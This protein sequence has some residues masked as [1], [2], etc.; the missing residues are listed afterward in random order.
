M[1]EKKLLSSISRLEWAKTQHKALLTDFKDYVD[2]NPFG[3]KLD[4][5]K[6]GGEI[7]AIFWLKK[8]PPDSKWG[9]MIGDVVHSLRT[10]LD[11]LVCRLLS[12][13]SN[14]PNV[15]FPI[16]QREIELEQA[17]KDRVPGVNK[18]IVDFLIEVSPCGDTN[19]NFFLIQRMDNESKHRLLTPSTLKLAN[20]KLS[21]AV[22]MMRVQIPFIKGFVLPKKTENPKWEDGQR[23]AVWTPRRGKIGAVDDI[24]YSAELFLSLG[25]PPEMKDIEPLG[26]LD[27]AIDL[28]EST[29]EKA[30]KLDVK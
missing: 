1:D 4:Q 29:I 17:I 28:V 6:F 3:V 19:R 25:H 26:M 30:S 2:S 27:D 22:K 18:E 21:V 7:T 10:S 24:T 15:Y 11:N 16:V 14:C 8:Y 23:L 12:P 5:P 9:L 13:E 20:L